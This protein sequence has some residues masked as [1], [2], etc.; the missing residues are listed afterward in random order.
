M[1]CDIFKAMSLTI[2]DTKATDKLY[3]T[4][5]AAEFFNVAPQTIRR[6]TRNGIFPNARK[7]NFLERR[8]PL[9]DLQRVKAQFE[10]MS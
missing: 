5:E 8:I 6:W 1:F 10:Q 9:S 3:T 4:N 2:D 7:I